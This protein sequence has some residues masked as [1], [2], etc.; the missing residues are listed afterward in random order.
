M[1]LKW[2][3][4]AEEFET[5]SRPDEYSS[6]RFFRSNRRIIYMD[7]KKDNSGTSHLKNGESHLN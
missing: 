4:K 1:G 7:R 2:R 5:W 6:D 3:L